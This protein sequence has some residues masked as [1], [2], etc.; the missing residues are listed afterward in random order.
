ME[1]VAKRFWQLSSQHQAAEPQHF[2]TVAAGLL[3][4][5]QLALRCH[6]RARGE[7][8]EQLVSPQ[9]VLHHLGS[10]HLVAWCHMRQGLQ[11]FALASVESAYLLEFKAQEVD[12]AS[13]EAFVALTLAV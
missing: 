8:S 5:R 11:S 12:H 4:R 3:S 7:R 10:W 9:V 13:V 2:E 6:D 1:D